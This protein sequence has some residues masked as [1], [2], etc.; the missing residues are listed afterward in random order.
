MVP[1]KNPRTIPQ[2]MKEKSSDSRD[3]D[4]EPYS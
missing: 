4:E 2:K 1:A 3:E